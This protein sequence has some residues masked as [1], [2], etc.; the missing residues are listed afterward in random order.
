[1]KAMSLVFVLLNF[2]HAG[3]RSLSL[4][5]SLLSQCQSVSK[6]CVCVTTDWKVCVCVCVC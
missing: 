5:Q 6:G 2:Q 1:M 4:R 3:V